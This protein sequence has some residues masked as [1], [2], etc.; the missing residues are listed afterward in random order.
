MT[1]KMRSRRGEKKLGKFGIEIE[2]FGVPKATLVSALR[3]AGINAGQEF[4]NHDTRSYWK[5]ISDC[6]IRGNMPFELVSPVLNGQDG[7][8]QIDKVCEVLDSLD[9][10]VNRSCGLHVHHDVETYKF[11]AD[12]LS[13]VLDVYRKMEKTVDSFLAPSR[14][15]N[16]NS[17]CKSLINYSNDSIERRG[18][19]YYKVNLQAF[20]RHGTVE[21]RHHQG[22]VNA[23]KI[24]NW[25][26]FTA[27][28]MNRS[29]KACKVSSD[30]MDWAYVKKLLG[31]DTSHV[32]EKVSPILHKMVEYIE[33][34]RSQ[35]RAA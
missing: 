30:H 25:V 16:N 3:A 2:A 9:A 11:K 20:Q 8:D 6:S 32:E 17:Y 27:L 22:T 31:I 18:C 15:G 1:L 7:L 24:K 4:Y 29:R 26:L 10:K 34:R 12:N 5:V 13:R 14:R 33:N 21:F 28:I 19:R 35:F 23:D